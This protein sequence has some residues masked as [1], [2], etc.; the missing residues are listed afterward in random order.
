MCGLGCGKERKS[1]FSEANN[2]RNTCASLCA[3]TEAII[4]PPRKVGFKAA[5][6]SQ[7]FFFGG[8]AVKIFLFYFK[9]MVIL[10]EENAVK[11]SEQFVNIDKE[12]FRLSLTISRLM[13]LHRIYGKIY[14]EVKNMFLKY[15]VVRKE[16][17]DAISKA[18]E[19]VLDQKNFSSSLHRLN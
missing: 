8:N 14:E 15:F 7:R 9:N 16:P 4:K 13:K 6:I 12:E 3:S 2:F 5:K 10:G 19:T 1:K 18:T 11:E 17:Q